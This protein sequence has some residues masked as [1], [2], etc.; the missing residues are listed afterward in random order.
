MATGLSRWEALLTIVGASDDPAPAFTDLENRATLR[1]LEGVPHEALRAFKNHDSAI[2][3][4]DA[5]AIWHPDAANAALNAF[6]EGRHVPDSLD[7]TNLEWVTSLPGNITVARFL[8]LRGTGLQALPEG[9]TVGKG[10]WPPATLAS[11]P[12]KLRVA[13]NLEL[14]KCPGWDGRIPADTHVGGQVYTDRHCLGIP[15]LDWRLQHPRGENG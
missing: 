10:F 15:L 14:K 2:L 4:F 5:L 12:K 3:A 6:L 11:L 13:G 9:L 8:W 7:L 1:F